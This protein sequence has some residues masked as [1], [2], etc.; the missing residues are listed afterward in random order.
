MQKLIESKK[1]VNEIADTISSTTKFC[2]S[3]TNWKSIKDQANVKIMVLNKQVINGN[4]V[5]QHLS[6]T[7]L[8]QLTSLSKTPPH[9]IESYSLFLKPNSPIGAF[10]EDRLALIYIPMKSNCILYTW[11]QE[12]MIT[13]PNLNL[14]RFIAIGDNTPFVILSKSPNTELV[15]F[16]NQ[17]SKDQFLKIPF[18][19]SSINPK[20]KYFI[21]NLI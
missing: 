16:F 11:Y 17:S 15:L 2:E 9:I 6:K 20:S 18:H 19:L 4:T 12:K 1:G 21:G 5:I 13:I 8:Q 7:S 3:T 10:V 14:D